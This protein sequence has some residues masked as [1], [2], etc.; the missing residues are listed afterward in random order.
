MDEKSVFSV[1]NSV[2]VNEHTET[3]KKRRH[4]TDL[5]VLAICVGGSQKAL[6]RRD[7]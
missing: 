5:P 7:V 4:R 3:K 1:L 6:P 2:N